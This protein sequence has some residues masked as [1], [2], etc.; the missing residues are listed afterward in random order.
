MVV[1]VYYSIAPGRP[2]RSERG[3][4]EILTEQKLGHHDLC[5]RPGDYV[6]DLS[7]FLRERR[8][9][10]V[11]SLDYLEGYQLMRQNFEQIIVREPR[12]KDLIREN[13]AH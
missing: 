6:G 8:T 11:M 5:Y 4:Q 10:D 3:N 9:A 7:F 13:A 12:L 2:S 1:S